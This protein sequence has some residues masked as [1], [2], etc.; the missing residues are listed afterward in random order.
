MS[1]QKIASVGNSNVEL[2]KYRLL[3]E[4]AR[5]GMAVLFVLSEVLG[6]ADR[7]LVVRDSEVSAELNGKTATEEVIIHTTLKG[8]TR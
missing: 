5:Q 3:N 8:A 6:L 2:D 7:I 1:M 4:F